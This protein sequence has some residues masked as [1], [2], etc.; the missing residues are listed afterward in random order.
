TRLALTKYHPRAEVR[1]LLVSIERSGDMLRK[2]IDDILDISRIEAGRMQSSR[3][4]FSVKELLDDVIEIARPVAQEHNTR[5]DLYA[6]KG[7]LPL[8]R[9]DKAHLR[10]VLLNVV[11]N[12]VKFTRNGVVTV[13]TRSETTQ[14]QFLQIEFD[15]TD[16]GIGIPQNELQ[17]I[18]E[19]LTQGT[20]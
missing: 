17:A 8:V 4:L 6:H 5:I 18:F 19:P 16:T 2:L 13:T 9:G 1:E 14:G 7:P 12:A 20:N 15:I 11:G 3:V 10:R